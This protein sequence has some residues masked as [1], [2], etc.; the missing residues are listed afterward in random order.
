MAKPWLELCSGAA[1]KPGEVLV[2]PLD[3]SSR[4]RHGATLGEPG[5]EVAGTIV[6]T[7]RPIEPVRFGPDA[8]ISHVKHLREDSAERALKGE[9]VG[10]ETLKASVCISGGDEKH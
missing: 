2:V 3:E 1:V 6:S 8:E 9:H 4:P 5:G 10:V 7:R